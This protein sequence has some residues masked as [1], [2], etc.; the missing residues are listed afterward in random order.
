MYHDIL[1]LADKSYMFN[2]DVI[3][4]SDWKYNNEGR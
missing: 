2:K 3:Y 4:L 1:L